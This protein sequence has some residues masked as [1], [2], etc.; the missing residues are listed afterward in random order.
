MRANVFYK[1]KK[2]STLLNLTPEANTQDG[3]RASSW[4]EQG[5]DPLPWHSVFTGGQNRR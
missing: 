1:R 2:K 3:Y 4:C 5:L